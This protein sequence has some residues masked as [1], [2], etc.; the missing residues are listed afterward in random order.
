VGLGV[1]GAVP[2]RGWTNNVPRAQGEASNLTLWCKHHVSSVV[3][4]WGEVKDRI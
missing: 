2:M 1:H 4:G 3:A